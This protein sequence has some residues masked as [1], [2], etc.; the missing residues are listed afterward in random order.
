MTKK[1]LT[2]LVV[3]GVVLLGGLAYFLSGGDLFQGRLSLRGSTSKNYISSLNLCIKPEAYEKKYYTPPSEENTTPETTTGDVP[4]SVDGSAGRTPS[5]RGGDSGSTDPDNGGSGRS[6]SSSRDG[7]GDSEEDDAKKKIVIDPGM[8]GVVPIGGGSTVAGND[9]SGDGSKSE[10]KNYSSE[11]PPAEENTNWVECS[12][13]RDGYT[14]ETKDAAG[15]KVTNICYSDWEKCLDP[16]YKCPDGTQVDWPA[17][18]DLCR[19]TAQDSCFSAKQPN[20]K[21]EN[22]CAALQPY[23]AYECVSESECEEY[24]GWFKQGK[25]TEN[26]NKNNIENGMSKA[27]T[28]ADW[29]TETWYK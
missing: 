25:L 26:M 6:G 4:V 8:I 19:K 29:Y 13:A 2:I 3:V 20:A 12:C 24:A 7:G 23:K 27:S 16:Q 17:L 21:V 1:N 15:K 14:W 9:G 22:L 10:D 18:N 11:T 5:N 28:C